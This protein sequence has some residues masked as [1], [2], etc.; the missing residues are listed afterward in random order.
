MLN[1]RSRH[2][3][4]RHRAGE[5]DRSVIGGIGLSLGF[6]VV[7]VALGGGIQHF[8]NPAS[9]LIVLGGTLGATLANFSRLDLSRAWRTLQQTLLERESEPHERISYF[10]SLAQQVRQ[11]GILVLE[12][13]AHTA[14]DSFIRK[15]LELAADGHSAAD[16]RRILEIESRIYTEKSGR[17]VQVFETMGAYA[18]AMGLIGTLIGLIQM[19][20]ALQNPTTVGASM[21]EALVTTFY[22]AVLANLIFLPIAGK[23]RNRTEEDFLIKSLT[24]EGIVSMIN[25]ENPLIV[26]QRL[27]SFLP[28]VVN[29]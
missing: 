3:W 12:Q 26:E 8:F 27:Q 21:A 5:L 14:P 25:Q 16:L 24:I 23:L 22:G 7:G 19:L 20:S 1:L 18:P 2:D 17:A 10:V 28:N 6:I 29:F 13:A 4:Q 15:G 9:L 11:D